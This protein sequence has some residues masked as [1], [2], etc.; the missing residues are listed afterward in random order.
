M[1]GHKP[2]FFGLTIVAT[3]VDLEPANGIDLF[4]KAD[5]MCL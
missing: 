5:I 3:T 2:D 4:F 1:P